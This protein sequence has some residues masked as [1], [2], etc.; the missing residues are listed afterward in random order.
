MKKVTIEEVLEIINKNVE[1]DAIVLEQVNDNLSELGMES[2]TFIQIIV[3]IEETFEC[4]IPDSKLL[5]SE[6]DTVQ[7]M[8][9]VL[10]ELYESQLVQANS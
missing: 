2:I 8:Y 6:M 10:Q 4:E 9:D 1:A 3:E 7:K 5:L